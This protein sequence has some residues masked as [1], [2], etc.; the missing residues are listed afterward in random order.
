MTYDYTKL[1]NISKYIQYYDICIMYILYRHFLNTYH[2]LL[3]Y[4]FYTGRLT[5]H[6]LP[7]FLFNNVVVQ[8]NSR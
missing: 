4:R 6:A 1:W 3:Y 7:P 2:Y 5:K 8:N